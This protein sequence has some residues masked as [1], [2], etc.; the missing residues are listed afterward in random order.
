MSPSPV[1]ATITPASC[2]R[3]RL[4]PR[5][6]KTWTARRS[7]PASKTK[8]LAAVSPGVPASVPDRIYR[9]RL[10]ETGAW[11]RNYPMKTFY[12]VGLLLPPSGGE[13][14]EATPEAAWAFCGGHDLSF[15][16]DC[17]GL[18]D[19]RDHRS[20][21]RRHRAPYPFSPAGCCTPA[22]HL[23]HELGRGGRGRITPRVAGQPVGGHGWVRRSLRFRP[24]LLLL[25][26]VVAPLAL[27]VVLS[28]GWPGL[29]AG[30]FSPHRRRSGAAADPDAHRCG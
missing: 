27:V 14:P 18:W 8:A 19:V 10:A 6:P 22:R 7:W 28:L 9:A 20:D 2:G 16:H 5:R 3:S 13:G 23:C 11:R 24:F 12:G 4:P 21:S 17:R 26:V 25:G 1:S 30:A 15:L 29:D